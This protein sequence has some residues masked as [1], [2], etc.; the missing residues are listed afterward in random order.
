MGKTYQ[1]R[2]TLGARSDTDDADGSVT[3]APGAVAPEPARVTTVLK[4]FEGVVEQVP[5]AYSAARVEGRRA[6]DLARGGEEGSL[7]A[8]PVRID[9]ITLDR[10]DYPDLALTIDC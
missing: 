6:Y 7:A 9:R 10:Y 8:R 2:L 1:T 5:P 4:G 3:P